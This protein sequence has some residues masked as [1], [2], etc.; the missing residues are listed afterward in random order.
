MNVCVCV[1]N[2]KC[3]LGIV[4]TPIVIIMINTIKWVESSS[5][6]DLADEIESSTLLN[7][8][9]ILKYSFSVSSDKSVQ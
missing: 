3:Y 7:T 6:D 5:F 2:N 9:Y 4:T 8:Q 1:Y